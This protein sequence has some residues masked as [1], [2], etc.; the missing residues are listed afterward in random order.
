M[1]LHTL[2]PRCTMGS[3]ERHELTGILRCW[4]PLPGKALLRVDSLG[5]NQ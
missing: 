5:L 1:E 2:D 3:V 4:Q